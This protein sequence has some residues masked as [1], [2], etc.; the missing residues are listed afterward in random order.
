MAHNRLKPQPG[1][2]FPTISN[3]FLFPLLQFLFQ[4]QNQVQSNIVFC[5]SSRNTTLAGSAQLVIIKCTMPLTP[6]CKN[7]ICGRLDLVWDCLPWLSGYGLWRIVSSCFYAWRVFS[8][9]LCRTRLSCEYTTCI[10]L[11][12]LIV[13][14]AEIHSGLVLGMWWWMVYLECWAG[15]CERAG[16]TNNIRHKIINNRYVGLHLIQ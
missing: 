15:N 12:T 3:H 1:Q 7:T 11:V 6:Q 2:C 8:F 14:L 16:R 9:L 10:R 5:P 13:N 4:V